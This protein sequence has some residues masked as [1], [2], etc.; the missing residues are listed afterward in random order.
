MRMLQKWGARMVE[1]G[2]KVVDH[3]SSDMNALKVSEGISSS[4]ASCHTA[5]VRAIFCWLYRPNQLP[6]FYEMPSIA[7]LSVL[8]AAGSYG[9]FTV[10]AES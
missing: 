1:G 10:A 2:Y 4:L 8:H 9:D 5:F 6:I 3:V 7:G